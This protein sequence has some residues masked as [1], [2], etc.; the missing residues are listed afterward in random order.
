MIIVFVAG[1]II[2]YLI[3]IIS[4]MNDELREIKRKCVFAPIKDNLRFK[5]FTKKPVDK[6]NAD[7]TENMKYLK[8]YFD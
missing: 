2:K 6:I 4:S 8:N 3:D 1:F 5:K 7:I